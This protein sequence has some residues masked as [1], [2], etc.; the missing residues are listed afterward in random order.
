MNVV[1]EEKLKELLQFAKDNTLAEVCWQEG[2]QKIFFRRNPDDVASAEAKVEEEVAAAAPPAPE[3]QVVRSPMVGTFRRGNSKNHP[4]FV[5]EGNHIKPGD[6]VGL[7]ES[8]KIPT[9]V[10]SFCEGVI[11]EIVVDDGQA[12]E[13]GQPLFIVTPATANGENGHV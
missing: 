4:P 11:K 8:M 13:Y 10:T 3:E 9:D 1:I 12:V 5:M 2:T 7:V 6:R